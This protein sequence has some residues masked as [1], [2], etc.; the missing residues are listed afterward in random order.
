MFTANLSMV[1]LY[2]VFKKAY[3]YLFSLA[4][5]VNPFDHNASPVIQKY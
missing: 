5:W 1:G 2:A 4:I 3:P